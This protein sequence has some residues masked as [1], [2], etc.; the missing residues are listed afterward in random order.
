M[1]LPIFY[2]MV[3][4]GLDQLLRLVAHFTPAAQ[5]PVWQA[6]GVSALGLLLFTQAGTLLKDGRIAYLTPEPAYEE[7]FQYVAEQRQADDAVLTMNT[8]AAALFL[9][10]TDYFAMQDDADQFLLNSEAGPVDRWLGAPWLGT[11]VELNRALNTHPQVWF[12]VDTI[13]LPEYYLGDWQSILK[14]QMDLVWANDNALV[15]R[16][17][18]DRRPLPDQPDQPLKVS[19]DDQIELLGYTALVTPPTAVVEGSL[20]LILFWQARTAIEQDYTVFVHLRDES[21]AN[22]VS[23]DAQ[24][25]EGEY[26]TA[27]WRVGETIIDSRVMPLSSDLAAGTYQLWTGMYLLETLERLPVVDDQSGENGINLG[28][29]T[30]PK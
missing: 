14:S 21:G 28:R 5:K 12:V 1:G 27:Q 19:L 8:S 25:L 7:A 29:L 26:P 13:R 23:R 24:P 11:A 10:Q 4:G 18:P 30:I 17:R 22:V 6:I 3:V 9:D 2:L 16:T 20:Q 15:Y